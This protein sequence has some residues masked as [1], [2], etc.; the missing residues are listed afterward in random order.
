MPARK[1]GKRKRANGEGS[2]TKLPSG[3]VRMRVMVEAEDGTLF[4]K[5]FTN[6]SEA[7]CRKAYQEWLATDHRKPPEKATKLSEW[8]QRW[9]DIYCKPDVSQ[10][11]YDDYCMYVNRH[12]NPAL[13]ELQMKTI[14]PAR[15]KKFLAEAKARPNKSY[16]EGK[17]LS[18]SAKQK[19][20]II[21]DGAFKTAVQNG[22]CNSNPLQ[23][24]PRP[25]KDQSKVVIFTETQMKAIASYLDKHE[26]GPYVAFFFY[27]G[28]RVGEL[29]G[30]MWADID[31]Q[32]RLLHVRR[33]LKRTENGKEVTEGTKGRKNKKKERSIPY[34]GSP[35]EKYI[36]QIV[37]HGMYVISR[38]HDGVLTHHTHSSFDSIYYK[39]FND[40]NETLPDDQK[41]PRLSCHKCRH[42]FATYSMKSGMHPVTVQ[43]LLGHSALA[44][45]SIYEHLDTK[46]LEENI[47]KLQ[48]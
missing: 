15:L 29:I 4:P 5:S 38:E 41:I 18:G 20:Y 30:L 19:L 12:I 3:K 9:L 23:T 43:K 8:L 17:P 26:Y 42:T 7:R 34:G 21:L 16:P 25:E 14:K 28:L 47:V 24:I 22:I 46:D 1:D 6:T 40:L 31:K 33:S 10:G 32:N 44:T 27:S 48:Y 37:P 2:F 11:T 39:F 36:D 13:G 45:T 35:L